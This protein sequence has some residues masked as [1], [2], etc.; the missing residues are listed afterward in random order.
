MNY[1]CFVILIITLKTNWINSFCFNNRFAYEFE[2]SS[3]T[4]GSSISSQFYTDFILSSYDK[5]SFFEEGK[6]MWL[7]YESTVV[8]DFG[9]K[10]TD[11][12]RYC[13][14]KFDQFNIQPYVARPGRN[15]ILVTLH[16]KEYPLDAPICSSF[17]DCGC[18]C[19]LGFSAP[20]Q[21]DTH[22]HVP[23]HQQQKCFRDHVSSCHWRPKTR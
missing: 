1:Y 7:C 2:F 4:N 23:I 17:I 3:P 11:S 5:K 22:K 20:P 16:H 8:D 19:R 15:H 9:V 14:N 18:S 6:H 13:G 21:D 12:I 10:L